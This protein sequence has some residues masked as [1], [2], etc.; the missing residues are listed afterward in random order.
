MGMATKGVERF[1]SSFLWRRNWIAALRRSTSIISIISGEAKTFT[2]TAI[3]HFPSLRIRL[4]LKIFAKFSSMLLNKRAASSAVSRVGGQVATPLRPVARCTTSRRGARLAARA[5][6]PTVVRIL[7]GGAGA[8]F[9]CVSGSANHYK[10]TH[11]SAPLIPQ[12]PWRMMMMMNWTPLC[13]WVGTAR[14][15]TDKWWGASAC[16][17]LLF[18]GVVTH[19]QL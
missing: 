9:G 13:W 4:K 10:H 7:G 12:T 15:G 8:P 11:R 14:A 16:I 1:L 3:W 2:C 17:P 18:H 6:E 5:A 19:T